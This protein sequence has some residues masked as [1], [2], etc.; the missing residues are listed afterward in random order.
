MR[1]FEDSIV[2]DLLASLVIKESQR[3]E[4]FFFA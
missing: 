2:Q 3:S 1:G 4:G